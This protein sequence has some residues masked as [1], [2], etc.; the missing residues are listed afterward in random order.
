MSLEKKVVEP[1]AAEPLNIRT[2]N[3]DPSDP[4]PLNPKREKEESPCLTAK[5]SQIHEQDSHS[6]ESSSSV[7]LTTAPK[8]HGKRAENEQGSVSVVGKL[9]KLGR[10]GLDGYGLS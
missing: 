9:A 7:D 3:P 4:L 6:A 2:S 1:H 5:A 8:M 10:N